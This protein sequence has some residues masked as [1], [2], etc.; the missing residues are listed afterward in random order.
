MT[1]LLK[2]LLNFLKKPVLQKDHNKSFLYRF[3]I[4][5]LLLVISISI[6]FFLSIVN[7]ILTSIGLL[8][9][10]NHLTDTLL[11][12]SSGLKILFLASIVAPITEELIFRAPL[13][14]FKKESVFK[15]AFYS[16]TI[17]FAY[18]HIFNFE[19]NNNVLLFSPLLV[20]P[21]FIVGLIFGF[22]RIRFGLLWAISLH[23]SYNGILVSLFLISTHGV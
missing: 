16:L 22:I 8:D 11:N 18:I 20:A 15:I 9:E 1:I 5:I 7:G 10:N 4:F 21:Q 13:V 6:S 17:I 23:G 2:E 19:I 3:K 12:G 14:L